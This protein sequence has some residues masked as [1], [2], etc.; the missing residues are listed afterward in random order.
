MI[1]QERIS[2]APLR[3]TKTLSSN[4]VTGKSK[5]QAFRREN[6]GLQINPQVKVRQ[7]SRRGRPDRRKADRAKITQV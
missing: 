1:G 5:G 7:F 4:D 2:Q 6:L 3:Q